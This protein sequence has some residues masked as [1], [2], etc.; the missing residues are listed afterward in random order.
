M[1]HPKNAYDWQQKYGNIIFAT[2]LHLHHVK[3]QC[4]VCNKQIYVDTDNALTESALKC[5][6]CK[7]ID[8][9]VTYA[10]Q[11]LMKLHSVMLANVNIDDILSK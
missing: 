6:S 10:A 4:I 5:D 2:S 3:W 1:F 11:S 7:H 9:N 8:A